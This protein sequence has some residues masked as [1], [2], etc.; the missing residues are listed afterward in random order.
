MNFYRG[1]RE[2]DQFLKDILD[3]TD[4]FGSL[5]DQAVTPPGQR[6]LPRSRYGE[7]LPPL[8]QGE[9]SGDQRT[10]AFGR[11]H[12]QHPQAQSA[13]DTIASGKVMGQGPLPGITFGHEGAAAVQNGAGQGAMALGIALLQPAA[14]Y[15]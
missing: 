2:L 10:T 11:L 7:H 12:H 1:A 6:I 15:G 13:D 14:Q 5:L 4:Q 8:L 9:T 3:F